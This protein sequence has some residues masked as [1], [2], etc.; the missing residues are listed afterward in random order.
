[1]NYQEICFKGILWYAKNYLTIYLKLKPSTQSS[2][3][4]ILS[5]YEELKPG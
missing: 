1:M 5:A 3:R 4:D 2:E